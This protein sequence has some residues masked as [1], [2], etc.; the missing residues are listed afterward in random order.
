MLTM[1][2]SFCAARAVAHTEDE[3]RKKCKQSYNNNDHFVA[4]YSFGLRYEIF[5]K[6]R[7][8]PGFRMCAALLP[9]RQCTRPQ[10]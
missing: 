2:C 9:D 10:S 6:H 5:R 8:A 4:R 1:T 7:F 3:L